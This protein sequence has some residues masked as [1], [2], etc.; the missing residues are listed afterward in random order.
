MITIRPSLIPGR[1]REG[2]AL[3]LH[4]ES[5]IHV[6]D[7]EFGHPQF[8]TKRSPAGELLYRLKYRL[9]RSAIPELV[10]AAAAF[11]RS[12]HP[13][14]KIVVP[15]PPTRTR[16]LQPVLIL[17]EALAKEIGI[18]FSPNCIRRAKE[19]PE[20]KDVYDYNERVRLLA[21]AHEVDA[22][23]VAGRKVLLFDDLYRSGATMSSIAAALH[24]QGNC[25]EVFAL[26]VTR[27]RSRR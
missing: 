1:W 6:G 5:A 16:T 27:T 13:P 22:P 2:Y 7:D 3:D 25:E 20:L 21:D 9:D 24:D 17:G 12:W 23:K 8:D 4:T 11:V 19:V 14:V 10:E 18:E 15:V 26:T